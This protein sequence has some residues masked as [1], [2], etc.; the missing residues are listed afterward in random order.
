MIFL[1]FENEKGER[2]DSGRRMMIKISVVIL[3]RL[4]FMK[5]RVI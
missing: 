4:L 1:L 2:R 5:I 3:K